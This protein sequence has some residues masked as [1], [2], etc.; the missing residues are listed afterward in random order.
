[1][2]PADAFPMLKHGPECQHF[3]C[4]HVRFAPLVVGCSGPW[5]HHR[6]RSPLQDG[7]C[8]FSLRGSS[9]GTSPR[10]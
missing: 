2:L 10:F 5:G 9:H 6:V 8:S 7:L 1:M 4:A 3:D